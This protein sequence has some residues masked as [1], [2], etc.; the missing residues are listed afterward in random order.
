TRFSPLPAPLAREMLSPDRYGERRPCVEHG[1]SAKAGLQALHAAMARDPAD[2]TERIGS[3]RCLKVTSSPGD[4]QLKVS[5]FHW[6]GDPHYHACPTGEGM[7]R[8]TFIALLGG[9]AAAWQ[10]AA[11]AQQSGPIRLIGVLMLYP[12]NDPQGE[13]RAAV[14]QRELEKAGWK[15]G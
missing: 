7:K 2:P 12:E 5:I 1:G 10:V 13:L 14:F 4:A 3:A 15:I 9:A 11:R 6:P 8:R